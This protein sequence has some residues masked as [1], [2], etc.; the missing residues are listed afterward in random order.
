MLVM[1]DEVDV[2]IVSRR[3]RVESHPV[4]WIQ[5]PVPEIIVTF[6]GEMHLK[7]SGLWRT[8]HQSSGGYG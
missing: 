1:E 6:S 8:W 2:G 4:Q 5:G 7:L 3:E